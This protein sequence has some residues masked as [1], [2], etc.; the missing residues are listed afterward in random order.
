MRQFTLEKFLNYKEETG[1]EPKV[2]SRDGK[3]ARII[4]VDRTTESLPILALVKEGKNYEAV[5]AYNKSGES[6]Q[7]HKYDLF[8][9]EMQPDP[10]YRP[11]S[12]AEECFAEVQKHGGWVKD[13]Y[14]IRHVSQITFKEPQGIMNDMV[15]VRGCNGRTYAEFLTDFDWADDGTPCGIKE[16]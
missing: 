1:K 3:S 16:Y 14:A 12:N 2:V 5:Y 7:G 9:A 13:K 15:Q 10:K 11:F 8:F 4:C 6:Q